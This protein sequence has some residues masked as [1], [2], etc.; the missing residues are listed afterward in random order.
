MKIEDLIA[1]NARSSALVA[2]SARPRSALPAAVAARLAAYDHTAQ[3]RRPSRRSGKRDFSH[4]DGLSAAV[5]ELA[6]QPERATAAMLDRA[7]ARASGAV[8][9]AGADQRSQELWNRAFARVR[10]QR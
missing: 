9:A 10:G 2:A 6:P 5:P 3:T 7:F 1:R 8:P 4:L